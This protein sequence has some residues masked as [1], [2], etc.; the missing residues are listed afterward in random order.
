MI[1]YFTFFAFAKGNR[2]PYPYQTNRRS[3]GYGG[4]DEGY[5]GGRS[6]D[7]YAGTQESQQSYAREDKQGQRYRDHQ[8]NRIDPDEFDERGRRKSGH[9]ASRERKGRKIYPIQCYP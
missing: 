2:E 4:D 5:T 8:S 1:L 6:R 7:V 9:R 3:G